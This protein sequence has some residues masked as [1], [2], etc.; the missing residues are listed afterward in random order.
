MVRNALGAA[1]GDAAAGAALAAACIAG[2]KRA[3]ELSVADFA[4]LA[5]ALADAR[6]AM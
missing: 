6:R 3:E 2:T 5:D 1:F 4:R